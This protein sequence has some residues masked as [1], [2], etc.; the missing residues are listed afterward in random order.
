MYECVP[1]HCAVNLSIS[2]IVCSAVW[3]AYAAN[4]CHTYDNVPGEKIQFPITETLMWL[5][6]EKYNIK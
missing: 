6:M 4:L 3:R 5:S 1:W 2:V